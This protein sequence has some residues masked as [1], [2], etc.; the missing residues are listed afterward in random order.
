MLLILIVIFGAIW[1]VNAACDPDTK[2][3]VDSAE[4]PIKTAKTEAKT[5]AEKVP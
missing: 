2:R 3:F 4:T 1:G 5:E